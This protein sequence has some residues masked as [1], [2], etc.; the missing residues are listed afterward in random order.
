MPAIVDTTA[1][2][3]AR[4][5]GILHED[6]WAVTALT[7]SFP[8]ALSNFADAYDEVRGFQVLNAAQKSAARAALA[9]VSAFTPL[10]FT[11]VTETDT[12]HGAIR[13]A[14]ATGRTYTSGGNVIDRE[15]TTATAFNPSATERGGDIFFH[16]DKYDA[17]ALNN[18]SWLTFFHETGHALGLEHAHENT[19]F[20]QVPAAW[21]AIEFTI[22]S[23][24]DYPGAAV[25]NSRAEANSYPQ[26]F[27]MLDIAALQHIYGA[28]YA[29]RAGND[30][31]SF[32][33]GAPLILETIWDGGGADTY[34]FAGYATNL[35]IDLEPGSW[36]NTNAGQNA[37]LNARSS[38]T[39]PAYAKGNV[40]NALLHDDDPRSLI[41]R[42][43]GGSGDDIIAGNR[44]D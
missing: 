33:P 27:M 14:Q 34:S 6:H 8:S 10:V 20:G 5:D 16:P 30:T 43:I 32:D 29:T 19:D 18:F 9:E 35:Q 31:Y 2:G 42:A 37:H 3:D 28:N 17:P 26:G 22:L 7:F 21:D 40:Y 44:A 39:D 25:G 23:Y 4:I 41:E 38:G 1:T 13:F 24:R 12:A 36:S 15:I 11:E